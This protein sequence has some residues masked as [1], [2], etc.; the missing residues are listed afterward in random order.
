MLEFKSSIVALICC[1]EIDSLFTPW[2]VSIDLTNKIL[3]IEKRNWFFIG[4]DETT[5]KL[6][7]I[8]NVQI[9][10]YIF[11]SNVVIKAFGNVMIVK[12]LKN[13]DALKIKDLII[14]NL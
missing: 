12:G 7:M 4:I 6:N 5:Y 11:G 3:K 1:G 14:K 9:N 2:K 10:N 8:R 13:E